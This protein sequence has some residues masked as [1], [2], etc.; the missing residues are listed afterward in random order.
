MIVTIFISFHIMVSGHDSL[1]LAEIN[2]VGLIHISQSLSGRDVYLLCVISSP[3]D[4]LQ[5]ASSHNMTI[6]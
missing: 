1:V 2:E 5:N 4:G 3:T 6:F